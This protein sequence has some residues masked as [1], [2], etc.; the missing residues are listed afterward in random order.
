[1]LPETRVYAN[2]LDG[3]NGQTPVDY[4]LALIGPNPRYCKPRPLIG[5]T[6]HNVPNE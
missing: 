3:V 5:M 4:F 6:A 1:M 2:L